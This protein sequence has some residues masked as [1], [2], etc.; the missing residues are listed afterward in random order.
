ML[1]RTFLIICPLLISCAATSTCDETSCCRSGSELAA[2]QP[3]EEPALQ[4][5]ALEYAYAGDVALMIEDLIRAGRTAPRGAAPQV[6]V[7][8]DR[9]TNSL[10]VSAPQKE[11]G[12][13]MALA[14]RLDIEVPGSEA[15]E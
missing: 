15:S 9:R 12:Q 10:L 14:A 5:I 1:I 7:L 2:E 6:R 8:A 13:I 3:A 11:L 4:V